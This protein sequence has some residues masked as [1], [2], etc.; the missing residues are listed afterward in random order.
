[1]FEVTA[2]KTEMVKRLIRKGA[3]LDDEDRWGR[4]ALMFEVHSTDCGRMTGKSI[5]LRPARLPG[6]TSVPVEVPYSVQVELPFLPV[7]LPLSSSVRAPVKRS[8]SVQVELPSLPVELLLSSSVDVPVKG[9]YSVQ[10]QLPSLPLELP[11]R[12]AGSAWCRRKF[13]LCFPVRGARTNVPFLQGPGFGRRKTALSVPVEWAIRTNMNLI[14]ARLGVRGGYTY[15]LL[16]SVGS[17]ENVCY[18]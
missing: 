16:A 1:M 7:E 13:V 9:P 4:T 8:Y 10:V 2:K 12:F 18:A 11:Y 5:S 3:N 14:S 6:G 15:R 17:E